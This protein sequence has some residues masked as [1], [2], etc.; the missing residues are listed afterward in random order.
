MSRTLTLLVVLLGMALGA[1]S[2]KVYLGHRATNR[3]VTATTPPSVNDAAAT[4][5]PRDTTTPAAATTR[6]PA[7]S[8]RSEAA[9]PAPTRERSAQIATVTPKPPPGAPRTPSRAV[10]P[11]AAPTAP[12]SDVTRDAT[13]PE[14]RGALSP[15]VRRELIRRYFEALHHLR[16]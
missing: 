4:A 12:T 10:P 6:A 14:D 5:T 16:D 1:A 3:G 2:V 9:E 8:E 7:A 13:G 11:A 15:E